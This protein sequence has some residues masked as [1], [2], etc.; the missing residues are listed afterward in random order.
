MAKKERP[1]VFLKAE[2]KEQFSI[3]RRTKKYPDSRKW[4]KLYQQEQIKI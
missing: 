1:C 2:P 4:K 3:K